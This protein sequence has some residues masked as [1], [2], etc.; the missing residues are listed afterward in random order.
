MEDPLREAIK[1]LLPLQT[2]CRD[3]VKT[4]LLAYA[5]HS[6]RRE[7]SIYL[8]F[9]NSYLLTILSVLSIYVGKYL[10]MLQSLKRAFT[11]DPD[12]PQL[13]VYLIHYLMLCKYIYQ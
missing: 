8:H 12:N 5:I 13:H 4:H 1:F 11:I 9:I 7:L 2:M 3:N 10:L 6:R